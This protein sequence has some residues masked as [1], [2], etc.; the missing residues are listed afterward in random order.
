MSIKNLTADSL[1][2][3]SSTQAVIKLIEDHVIA[4]KDKIKDA[5][6][7][8]ISSI[9]YTLPSVISMPN[10]SGEDARIVLYSQLITKLEEDGFTA[11]IIDKIDDYKLIVSWRSEID[12]AEMEQM[13]KIVQS[14]IIK[15]R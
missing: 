7:N 3:K 6:R 15:P 8:G 14:H 11:N 9:T 2:K 10:I 4:I 12:P 13:R 1:Y 5:N